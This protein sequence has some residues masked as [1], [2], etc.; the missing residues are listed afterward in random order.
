M[1]K[2]RLP[3][4]S[5]NASFP[6]AHSGY[7]WHMDRK[8]SAGKQKVKEMSA[9]GLKRRGKI[10]ELLVEGKDS[11]GPEAAITEFDRHPSP[12]L[13]PGASRP[14]ALLAP[15][16]TPRPHPPSDTEHSK[17]AFLSSLVPAVPNMARNIDDG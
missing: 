12:R 2:P 3:L 9:K 11:A 6:G 16:D 15:T 5:I 1:S 13:L 7:H 4:R 8:G 10:V 17:P 14:Q